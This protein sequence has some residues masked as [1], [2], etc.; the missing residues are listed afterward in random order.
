MTKQDF[1]FEL[2]DTGTFALVKPA[3]AEVGDFTALTAA[4]NNSVSITNLTTEAGA[5]GKVS[6]TISYNQFGTSD[7]TYS[8]DFSNIFTITRG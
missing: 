7:V 1:V 8:I 3:G 6:G 4:G 2:Q 5:S